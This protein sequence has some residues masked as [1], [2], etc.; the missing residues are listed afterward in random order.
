MIF[1]SPAPR[2]RRPSKQQL[3]GPMLREAVGNRCGPYICPDLLGIFQPDLRLSN[4][5]SQLLLAE[6]PLAS[7]RYW[8]GWNLQSR[9]TSQLTTPR[10]GWFTRSLAVA[11][12]ARWTPSAC[13]H[14]KQHFFSIRILCIIGIVNTLLYYLWEDEHPSQLIMCNALRVFMPS[15]LPN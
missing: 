9:E 4:R 7:A 14:R 6:V 1:R 5:E 12:P 8:R 10:F 11:Q 13:R 2:R 15:S 3:S